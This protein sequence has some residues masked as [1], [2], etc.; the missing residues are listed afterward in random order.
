MSWIDDIN[1]KLEEQRKAFQESIDSGEADK[2]VKKY[3]SSQGA[4]S[5]LKNGIHNFQ[6]LDKETRVKNAKETTCW[7]NPDIQ[8]ENNRKAHESGYFQTEKHRK[9][10][11]KAAKELDQPWT[12]KFCNKSG[13][14]IGNFK[15]YGHHNG[16]CKNK[17]V[18]IKKSTLEK[19]KKL[20]EGL[21]E[22]FTVPQAQEYSSIL[23]VSKTMIYN[24]VK[25]NT[26]KIHKG[27]NGSP[28]DL[29]IY[30]KN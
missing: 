19:Y 6:L 8:K 2:R 25:N 4:K 22:T 27:K 5:Q 7:K 15:R 26:I 29:D 3:A 23:G 18:Y 12:C 24:W 17:K 30:K 13:K 16:D 1:K 11:A 10:A 28:T 20:Q 21:P 9:T 14:G